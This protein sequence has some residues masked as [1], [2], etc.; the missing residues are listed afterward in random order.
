[1]ECHACGAELD[2]RD[3]FCSKCGAITERGKGASELAGRYV[4]ELADGFGKLFAAALGYVTNPENRKRVAIGGAVAL[5]L[6]ISLTSNP[7]SRG[8]GGL[9]NPSQD[10]PSFNDDGT[11]NFAEY[12]DVFLG[13]EAEYYVTGVANVRNYPTGQNTDVVGSLAEGNRVMAREVRAFDRNSQ[14][15]KLSTGGYVWGRNLAPIGG[16]QS[17]IKRA[18]YARL[19]GR[20][21]VSGG[22]NVESGDT[23][24]VEE[25]AVFFGPNSYEQDI[26]VEPQGFRFFMYEPGSGFRDDFLLFSREGEPGIWMRSMH[27]GEL[28]DTFFYDASA[29]CSVVN[30]FDPYS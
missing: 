16:N 4:A 1:M 15:L 27:Q 12:E 26:R 8:V 14:W 30:G 7:I 6:L 21:H 18:E 29:S 9:F 10:V 25:E 5:V 24:T 20:W 22:C 2:P 17:E 11:P 19:I 13:D 3:K 28:L 23:L